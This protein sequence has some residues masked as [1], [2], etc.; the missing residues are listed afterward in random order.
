[1]DEEEVRSGK[2]VFTHET[3]GIPREIMSDLCDAGYWGADED[4]DKT[5]D[6]QKQYRLLVTIEEV[7]E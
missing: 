2:V 7:V 4:M 3:Q 5:W 1:M 6:S